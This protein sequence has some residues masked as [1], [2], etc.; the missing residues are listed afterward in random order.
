MEEVHFQKTFEAEQTE[1]GAFLTGEQQVNKPMNQVA[2][3]SKHLHKWQTVTKDPF[4]SD[5][6]KMV[7]Q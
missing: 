4:I 6:V 5:T 3:I 7:T 2:Q 1:A